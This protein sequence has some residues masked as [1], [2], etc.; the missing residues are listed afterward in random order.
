MCWRSR[1]RASSGKPTAERGLAADGP[2]E[3]N[4][5]ILII[6]DLP[7][8]LRGAAGLDCWCEKIV[9]RCFPTVIN[10]G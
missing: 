7:F 9:I 2:A 5:Q 6:Y 3:G 8:T 1:V 4:A 10:G